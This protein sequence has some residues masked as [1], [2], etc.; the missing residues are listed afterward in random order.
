[1]NL[2]HRFV[3]T[4][5]LLPFLWTAAGAQA[6]SF[7][8]LDS[9]LP[10][11]KDVTYL[12]LARMIVPDLVEKDGFYVG[13]APIKMRDIAATEDGTLPPETVSFLNAAVVA[14]R[15]GGQD[16]LAMLFDL[17]QG[18]DSAEGFAALALY[19]ISGKPTLLDVTNVAGDKWTSFVEPGKLPL[20]AAD[21]AL[22]TMSMHLNSE[23]NYVSMPLILVRNDRFEL[24]DLIGTF[25]ENLCAY[26]RMQDVGFQTIADGQPYA[27][28]KVTVTDA[29]VPNDQSCDDAPP[30]AASQAISVTYHW[31]AKTSHYVADSDAFEKLAVENAKRF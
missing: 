7:P 20:S 22:V 23:Q 16:R 9:A 26:K 13:S 2:I 12:D 6:V 31:E 11:R 14:M 8:E 28:I 30:K 25:N 29:T 18:S 17:G 3:L 1:M 10:G 27:A 21:D 24:I 19:D 5:L 4:C 15:A